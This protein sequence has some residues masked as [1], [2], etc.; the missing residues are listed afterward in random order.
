TSRSTAKK[1]NS[2][3]GSH[4]DTSSFHFSCDHQDHRC[5]TCS[6]AVPRFGFIKQRR[7][8]APLPLSRPVSQFICWHY[9]PTLD[10]TCPLRRTET[11]GASCSADA[12]CTS[13]RGHLVYA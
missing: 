3:P 1:S 5:C 8:L 6:A 2:Q 13:R 7:Q 12:T 10:L 9:P 4:E 11:D